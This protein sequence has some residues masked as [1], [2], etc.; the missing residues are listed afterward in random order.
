M[1][2]LTLGASIR[3]NSF[4][5]LSG[6]V[7]GRVLEFL[8]GI[9][10]ARILVPEDFGLLVTIQIFTGFLGYIS[11]GGMGEALVQAKSIDKRDY[12][13]VFTVQSAIGVTI[14]VALFLFAPVMAEWFDDNRYSDL[15]RVT[16]L[17]FLFR[18][19]SNVPHAMLR[20][21][22][23]F[24]SVAIV[25]VSA[26]LVS[27]V[28]SIA[29]AMLDYGTWA[30][31]F[32]G[33]LGTASNIVLSL[34]VTKWVP[35]FG[36]DT[37]SAKTLGA[38]GVRMSINDLV[39][40]GRTRTTLFMISHQLGPTSV[41]LYNRA[42]SLAE[43]PLFFIAGSAYQ[44][45]FRALS[46]TQDNLDQS[47]YIFLRTI[48]LVSLYSV[49]FFVCMFWLAE[50]FILNVYGPNWT[51]AAV[52]LQILAAFSVPRILSN[53]SGAVIAAQNRL[54]REIQ[55]QIESW[56]LLLV[57][58]L[59]GLDWGIVGIAVG[60]LPSYFYLSW[61]MG[62]IAFSI[63]GIRWQQ[64]FRALLPV[65]WLNTLLVLVLFA[66][67][68]ALHMLFEIGTTDLS[69]LL[70]T[71]FVAVTFYTSMILFRPGEALLSESKRWWSLLS[72]VRSSLSFS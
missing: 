63:L 2:A 31:V 56:V 10:L 25:Q 17:T 27:G 9:V 69:Y 53:V 5:V 54:G 32:G 37:G 44:T 51:D 52:P 38:Y 35:R 1:R 4:W 21:Q 24:R 33:L 60:M 23:R 68:S 36:F 61:R 6:R 49:P 15:L 40:Y 3:K 42:D 65:L 45:V 64:L 34:F 59:V 48:V 41:G 29:L 13:M 22:M 58:I 19:F 66:N 7:S 43:A 8:F 72:Q 26:I 57:G 28:S 55:A 50:S 12:Q 30:L 11:G 39:G 47:T 71:S 16:A 14:F 62:R 46:T 70:V 20:R 18:P 67:H